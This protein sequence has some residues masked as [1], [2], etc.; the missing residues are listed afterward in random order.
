[1]MQD[2]VILTGRVAGLHIFTLLRWC[3]AR[4]ARLRSGRDLSDIPVYPGT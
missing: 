1:M 4:F 3:F 2:Q